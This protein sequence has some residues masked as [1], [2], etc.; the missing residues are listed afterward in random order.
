MQ[1]NRLGRVLGIGA[2]VAADKLREG[3][4]RAAAAAQRPAPPPQP[5]AAPTQP[6]PTTTRPAPAAT[7]APKRSGPSTPPPPSVAEGTRR[8]ARGAGRFSASLWRPFAHATGILTLQITGMF[9][10]M[11]TLVFAV[12]SW[13][14]YKT[15]GW[16]DHHLPLYAV[17]AVLFAWFTI[18]S[19]WR[20]NRRQ[21][22][23]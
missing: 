18:S 8:L 12:H 15:A 3:T 4:A 23:T 16:R 13:Q 19:F 6:A 21:K 22:R 1:P 9:F 10:A 20:A 5:A 2:R 17:F 11:F 14:L 7:A